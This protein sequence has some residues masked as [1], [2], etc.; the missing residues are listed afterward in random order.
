MMQ[1]Y[2]KKMKLAN[3]LTFFKKRVH[4][5]NISTHPNVIVKNADGVGIEPTLHKVTVCLKK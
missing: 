1:I 4:K 5:T 2:E 3:L